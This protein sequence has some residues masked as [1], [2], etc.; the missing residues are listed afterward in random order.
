MNISQEDPKT[1]SKLNGF[2]DNDKIESEKNINI[3]N[4]NIVDG[5][6]YKYLSLDEVEVNQDNK[7]KSISINSTNP[8]SKQN[9]ILNLENL[10]KADYH[11]EFIAKYNDFSPSWRKECKKMKGF[12]ADEN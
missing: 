8:S 1:P 10:P 11:K 4:L 12:I 5:S 7:N 9:F 2:I 3:D 6:K